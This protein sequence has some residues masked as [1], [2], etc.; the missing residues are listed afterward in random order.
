MTR[1]LSL[2]IALAL[3]LTT[4]PLSF[5]PQAGESPSG[6]VRIESTS[7]AVGVGVTWGDGVLTYQGKD[8][9]FSVSGLS[10]VDVGVSKVSVVGKVYNL[11]KVQ[12]LSGN[13]AAGG[14][15]IAV[16]G[17]AAAQAMK[18]QHGVTIELTATQTGVKFTLAA[19]GVDIKLKK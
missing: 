18:N 4:L 6:T 2:G 8:Y 11:K 10:V 19:E 14:A 16:G 17:G 13:Y 9:K 15:G 3:V 7:V 12:D 5:A 1:R